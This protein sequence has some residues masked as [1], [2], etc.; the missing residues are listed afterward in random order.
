M[1]GGRRAS[2][3]RVLS[4][5]LS[6]AS[7]RS[8]RRYGVAPHLTA[9]PKTTSAPLTV[10]ATKLISS[11]YSKEGVLRHSASGSLVRA[12]YV[13]DRSPS[14]L[15]LAAGP[16]IRWSGMPAVNLSCPE[17]NDLMGDER[18]STD[19]SPSSR[20][21]RGTQFEPFRADQL[22]CKKLGE[23]PRFEFGRNI[24]EAGSS[25]SVLS[26][27]EFKGGENARPLP[28]DKTLIKLKIAWHRASPD[29][30]QSFLKWLKGYAGEQPG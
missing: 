16:M 20:L 11:V 23:I 18:H 17:R 24:Q 30:R 4:S 2:D 13:A 9:W 14:E 22:R 3:G 27:P 12:E 25:P 1:G 15:L 26:V 6:A 8:S 10:E 5:A 19:A 28:A 29:A 7:E 21:E